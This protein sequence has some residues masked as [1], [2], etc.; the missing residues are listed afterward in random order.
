MQSGASTVLFACMCMC[1]Y[2]LLSPPFTAGIAAPAGPAAA[3]PTGG[4]STANMA[5]VAAAGRASRPRPAWEGCCRW[6][7]ARH[8]R[9]QRRP[10]CCDR[11]NSGGGVA[12][13]RTVATACSILT[14]GRCEAGISADALRAPR[15]CHP[16]VRCAALWQ[17]RGGGT[18]AYR[19]VRG[20]LGC[21]ERRPR[22]AAMWQQPRSCVSRAAMWQRVREC[23]AGNA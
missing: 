19:R 15:S 12:V 22:C 3:P 9:E 7:Q 23:T 4:G 8:P 11:G 14:P 13:L 18:P 17:W 6:R 20:G 10:P 5:T 2:T 1:M 21:A 16:A